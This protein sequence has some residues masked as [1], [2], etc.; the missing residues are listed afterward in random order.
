MNG[1]REYG[2]RDIKKNLNKENQ[3]LNYQ[4]LI[5]AETRQLINVL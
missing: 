2:E 4:T 5:V 1:T 3:D